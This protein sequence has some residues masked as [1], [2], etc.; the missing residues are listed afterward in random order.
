MVL[1]IRFWPLDQY[2]DCGT[3]TPQGAFAPR[4]WEVSA[5]REVSL[6]HLH[7]TN[8]NGLELSPDERTLALGYYNGTAVWKDFATG[9]RKAFFPSRDGGGM[10]V[11]FSADG[12]WFVT[13]GI[14]NGLMTLC[15][16]AS[17]RRTHIGPDKP[18]ILH[19]LV[20]SPDGQRLVTCGAS[21]G[22]LF[23]FWDVVTG[24]HLLSLPANPEGFYT[25]L[26]FSPDGNTLFAASL[27][28]T[29]LLWRAPSWEQIEAA[30]KGQE[31][32]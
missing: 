4:F 19:T 10:H 24:R 26:G 29:A 2:L 12:R 13:G 16:L 21:L 27:E 23:R 28:G 22:D 9:T 25:R 6:E 1:A 3:L 15:E 11:K 18:Y 30:E 14:M 5:W 8:I 32:P 7:L 20:F 31:G 17:G